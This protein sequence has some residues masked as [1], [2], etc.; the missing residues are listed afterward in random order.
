MSVYPWQQ[1]AWSDLMR[2][3]ENLPHALLIHGARGS[4][5]CDFA[6]ALVRAL[7]CG[8]REASGV[9]CGTC[10]SCNWVEQRSHPDFAIVEPEA[11]S[12]QEM[13]AEREGERRKRPSAQIGVDQVRDLAGFVNL[14][15]HRGARR[16]VLIH[17]A[18]SLNIQAANAL[19]KTLEEPPPQAL[20]LLVS[21]R[22]HRI[23]PTIRSRCQQVRICL[24]TRQLGL[25]WL[26]GQGCPESEVFLALAGEAPL[27]ALRQAGNDASR[28]RKLLAAALATP[29]SSGALEVA[30]Q[31]QR[32]PLADILHWLQTWCYDLA[33]CKLGKGTRYHLDFAQAQ[34]TLAA[35]CETFALLDF[36]RRLSAA[37][38]IAE[39]P[40][41]AR[42]FLESILLPYFAMF[43]DDRF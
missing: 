34:R 12:T 37:R 23:A 22:A 35:R 28:Q 42:L 18:E 9:A 32:Y 16:I 13:D 25:S 10:A 27:E 24:P 14:T 17:P 21:H 1:A 36:E 20:F 38:R 19:L 4:G 7:L 31:T 33:A 2:R 5:K 15:S 39:Q 43:R 3:G 30:E 11:V 40:L 8:A 41:N 29:E 26:A 6:V